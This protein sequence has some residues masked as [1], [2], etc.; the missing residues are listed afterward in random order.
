MKRLTC[1]LTLLVLFCTTSSCTQKSVNDNKIHLG[2]VWKTNE[3]TPGTI[4]FDAL[5]Y[6]LYRFIQAS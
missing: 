5:A 2:D 4:L 1:I 3:E 6:Y